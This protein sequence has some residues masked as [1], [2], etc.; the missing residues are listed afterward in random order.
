M[1]YPT[2]I[3]GCSRHAAQLALCDAPL[4]LIELRARNMLDDPL[5]AV[6]NGFPENLPTHRRRQ[7]A[8][9][10]ARLCFDDRPPPGGITAPLQDDVR[11]TLNMMFVFGCAVCYLRRRA[12]RGLAG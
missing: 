1:R 4:D 5:F 3:A 12:A 9:E 10:I 8:A 11:R 6:M 7:I 2:T